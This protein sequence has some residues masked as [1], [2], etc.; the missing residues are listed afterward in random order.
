MIPYNTS[1]PILC[2]GGTIHFDTVIWVSAPP[3]CPPPPP[4]ALFLRDLVKPSPDPKSMSLDPQ[5]PFHASSSSYAL[6]FSLPPCSSVHTECLWFES[7]HCFH[8][9]R[10]ISSVQ[11]LQNLGNLAEIGWHAVFSCCPW[12]ISLFPFVIPSSSLISL[13]LQ[14]KL[15]PGADNPAPKQILFLPPRS[16]SQTNSLP[17]GILGAP[18]FLP[19]LHVIN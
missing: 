5:N 1:W 17:K 11:T 8:E 9:N 12:S 7:T 16:G 3:A 14:V 19:S 6:L 10:N 2:F 15:F 18:C 13:G 4:P